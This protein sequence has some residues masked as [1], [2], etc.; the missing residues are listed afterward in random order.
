MGYTILTDSNH[1]K[2]NTFKKYMCSSAILLLLEDL[3]P[4]TSQIN[5]VISVW[6]I[7]QSTIK[8]IF[9]R[10]IYRNV[11]KCNCLVVLV[12]IQAFVWDYFPVL[13]SLVVCSCIRILANLN[14]IRVQVYLNLHGKDTFF[15]RLNFTPKFGALMFFQELIAR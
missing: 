4:T 8:Q 2:T 7:K 10:D 1:T 14:N 6:K 12:G 11:Q 3:Q 5:R 13:G 15:L 9:I